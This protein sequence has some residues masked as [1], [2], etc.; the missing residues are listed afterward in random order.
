MAN[1]TVGRGWCSKCQMPLLPN[2]WTLISGKKICSSCLNK[3]VEAK[4]A[5][6]NDLGKNEFFRY[7]L[8]FFPSLSQVPES[9]Y[10]S[11]EAM[12]KRQWTVKNIRNTITYCDQQGKKISEENWSQLVYVYYNEAVAWVERLRLLQEKNQQVDLTQKV[13]TVPF[14]G[15]SYR[16]MPK[17]KMEDL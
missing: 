3:E 7:L 8:S 9:W 14:K 16:D 13:V 6:E 17:Y 12:L 1:Q 11:L 4:R 5:K 2:Q 10:A 15:T